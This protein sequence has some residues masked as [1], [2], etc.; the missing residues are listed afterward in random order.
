MSHKNGSKGRY[1]PL[2]SK[3]RQSASII[4]GQTMQ[5]KRHTRPLPK[6]EPSY[7]PKKIG[8]RTASAARQAFIRGDTEDFFEF[9]VSA[10]YRTVIAIH[11]KQRKFIK[12]E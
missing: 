6:I 11:K 8:R 9:N 2:R 3:N 10:L 12:S 1:A 5:S 4:K 7:T